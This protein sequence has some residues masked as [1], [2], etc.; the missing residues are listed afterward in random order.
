MLISQ[1]IRSSARN[2]SSA[3]KNF[4]LP[5]VPSPL[6]KSPPGRKKKQN[7][8]GD[9]RMS[10]LIEHLSDVSGWFFDADFKRQFDKVLL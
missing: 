8:N 5:P 1:T 3:S 2:E 6:V 4:Y 10:S 9:S 7:N